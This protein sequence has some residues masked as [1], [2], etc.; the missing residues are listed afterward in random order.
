MDVGMNSMVIFGLL[1]AITVA[2]CAGIQGKIKISANGNYMA[3]ECRLKRGTMKIYIPGCE[4]K[5]IKSVG[6]KGFCISSSKPGVAATTKNFYKLCNCCQPKSSKT[7]D[8]FLNCPAMKVKTRRVRIYVATKCYC[9]PC[10][11]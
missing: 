11:R 8:V 1:L 2:S 5:T 10:S 7:Q 6:C 9:K 4:Q 3:K